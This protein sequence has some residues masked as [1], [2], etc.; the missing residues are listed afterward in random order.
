MQPT[1][2]EAYRALGPRA[3]TQAALV[4]GAVLASGQDGLTDEEGERQTGLRVQSYTARRNGLARDGLVRDSGR[5][6]RTTSGREAIVWVACEYAP[7]PQGGA[8]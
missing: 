3:G 2:I 1:S 7:Q 5:T 6:R 8:A 4:Y